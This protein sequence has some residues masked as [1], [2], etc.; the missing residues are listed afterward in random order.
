M[1]RHTQSEPGP[2]RDASRRGCGSLLGSLTQSALGFV[3]LAGLLLA[4][5]SVDTYPTEVTL[6]ELPNTIAEAFRDEKN[7]QIK[8]MAQQATQALKSR[9]YTV[10]HGL[11]RQLNALPNL[12]EEQ[13]DLIAGGVLTVAENLQ[14]AAASGNVQAQQHLQ[15][16]TIV[17]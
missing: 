9:Q 13:Q 14:K 4:G 12:T 11:L 2:D 5:C 16:Q 8:Q 10:A 3:L 17:K 1:R 6:E 15:R 7:A